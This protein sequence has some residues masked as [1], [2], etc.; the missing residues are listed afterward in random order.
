M[1]CFGGDIS[2]VLGNNMSQESQNVTSALMAM[3]TYLDSLKTVLDDFQITTSVQRK[4]KPKLF[5]FNS[6]AINYLL[7]MITLE[8][9][10]GDI[11][12]PGC[13]L[14]L[15]IEYTNGNIQEML[16]CCLFRE[17]AEGYAL[18]KQLLEE[19]Y[20][21]NDEITQAWWNKIAEVKPFN[22][23]TEHRSFTMQLSSCLET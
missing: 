22:T 11:D 8:S 6:E 19:Q 10:C 9:L 16:Q 2:E 7:F 23:L 14:N 12:K 15:H 1:C 13:L 5:T 21:D 4:P 17:P 18:A 3:A 20:G